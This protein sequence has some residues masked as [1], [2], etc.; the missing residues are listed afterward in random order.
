MRLVQDPTVGTACLSKMV[1]DHYTL[2][3]NM[4]ECVPFTFISP[5]IFILL[6]RETEMEGRREVEEE[7]YQMKEVKENPPHR[8]IPHFSGT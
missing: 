5:A 2:A 6:E 3:F 7:N 1:F 4:D 8:L